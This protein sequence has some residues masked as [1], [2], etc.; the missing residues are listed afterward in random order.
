MRQAEDAAVEKL[1]GKDGNYWTDAWK[2]AGSSRQ[3]AYTWDSRINL[4]HGLDAFQFHCRFDRVYLYNVQ[5]VQSFQLM[6]NTPMRSRPSDK[7]TNQQQ[8]DYYLSD[9]FGIVTTV[10]I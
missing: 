1:L 4:Y 8:Y 10:L 6:A 5:S 7:N 2:Q 3:Q 9:H